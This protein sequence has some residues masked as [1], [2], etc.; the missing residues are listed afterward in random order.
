MGVKET[1][2]KYE[3]YLRKDD[4]D[5]VFKNIQ[6]TERKELIDFLYNVCGV[7]VLSHMTSIPSRMFEGTS[8]KKLQIPDNI[9]SIDSYA[10]P[11]SALN[12]VYMSD[13]V[14]SLGVGAFSG[15]NNLS[16]IRL[17]RSLT[18]IPQNCFDGCISLSKVF[19]PD[20]VTYF[21]SNA[22]ANCANDLLLVANHRKDSNSKFKTVKSEE[23]FYKKHLKF[24][25]P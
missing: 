6:G 21:G 13:S 5:E 11:M 8:I 14:T 7:D 22:F 10:F 9:T 24:K 4:Y 17:S 18:E 2:K 25:R 1:I 19:I 23:G 15:C 12:E 3:S 20:S 16:K